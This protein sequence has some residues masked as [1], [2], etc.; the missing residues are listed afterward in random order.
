MLG[1]PR[2]LKLDTLINQKKI[3][4]PVG[5]ENFVKVDLIHLSTYQQIY[6]G[7]YEFSENLNLYKQLLYDKKILQMKYVSFYENYDLGI[8]CNYPTENQIYS[9]LNHIPNGSTVVISENFRCDIFEKNVKNI[10]FIYI[11]ESDVW[12]FF[13]EKNLEEYFISQINN[14]RL[15]TTKKNQV[16]FEKIFKS[17]QNL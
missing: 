10:D 4:D 17:V 6:D 3:I 8:I 11:Q 2:M 9:K 5:F 7:T 14:D 12:A 15:V 1:S 13:E 16:V